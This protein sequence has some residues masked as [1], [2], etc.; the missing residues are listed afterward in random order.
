MVIYL[1]LPLAHSLAR[2][3]QLGDAR[4]R[5]HARVL[6]RRPQPDRRRAR[7]GRA[8]R[9]S[10]RS[11]GSTR[12]C[13]RRVLNGVAEQSRASSARSSTG[14]VREGARGAR[15]RPRGHA[16]RPLSP[17][18]A[19]RWPTSSC[20][21]RCA[22]CSATASRWRCAAPRRSRRE[23]LEFFDACGVLVLEG[24]GMTE[25]CAAATLNTPR[26]VRFGSV[27]RAAAGH[28]GRDRR[29]TARC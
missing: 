25:T 11:R 18:R 7:R 15:R 4:G 17:R 1:F 21:R 6:G 24:Y 8:R 27:G 10:R 28:R 13:T 29:R 14:R 26:A 22:A 9:T 20:S 3:A 2:V 5:R 19:T 23:V 16:A 12:R